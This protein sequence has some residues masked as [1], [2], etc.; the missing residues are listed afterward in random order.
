MIVMLLP[1][2]AGVRLPLNWNAPPT[3]PPDR[4]QE[5]VSVAGA[6]CG[7]THAGI[8]MLSLPEAASLAGAIVAVRTPAAHVNT[9]LTVAPGASPPKLKLLPSDNDTLNAAAAA[10]PRFTTVKPVALTTPNARLGA[11]GHDGTEDAAF[12][13][14]TSLAG[15]IVAV[16]TLA[17][18]VN[19]WLTVAPGASPPKLKRS[20]RSINAAPCRPIADPRHNLVIERDFKPNGDPSQGQV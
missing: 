9:W 16:R 2:S 3:G 17:A 4:L 13:T 19:T 11:G 10:A 15:A 12:P 18:H 8:W 14:G 6:G 20:R 5:R 1:A 7:G